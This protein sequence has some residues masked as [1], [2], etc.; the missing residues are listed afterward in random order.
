MKKIILSDILVTALALVALNFYN[1]SS[2]ETVSD[3]AKANSEALAIESLTYNDG[4]GDLI[5][6]GDGGGGGTTWINAYKYQPVP[7]GSMGVSYAYK[8]GG[9]VITY[10]CSYAKMSS[11]TSDGSCY[12]NW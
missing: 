11:P 2:N 9:P 10:K 4:S 1:N 6:D 7:D 8:S 5:G 3:V 12:L